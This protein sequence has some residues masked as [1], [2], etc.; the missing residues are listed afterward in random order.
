M[1]EGQVV[2]LEQITELAEMPS[3]E[4]LLSMLLSV[5]QAPMRNF[6]LAV[7]AVADKDGEGE[8]KTPKLKRVGFGRFS[9]S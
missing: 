9:A 1:V 3:R 8:S 2:G 6:A 7:Q 4:G 5:L